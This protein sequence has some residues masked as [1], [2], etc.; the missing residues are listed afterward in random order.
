MAAHLTHQEKMECIRKHF[1]ERKQPR[2]IARELGCSERTVERVV[3]QFIAEG[4]VARKKGSGRPSVV[5]DEVKVAIE[6]GI[7]RK[8][9]ATSAEL[10]KVVASDTG[11][12]VSERTI[13]RTRRQLRYHPVHVSVKPS[14]SAVHIQDR[15]DWCRAHLH[16][17]VRDFVFMDEMGVCIDHHRRVSWIKPGEA[18]PVEEE[19]PFKARL[20]VWGC[21][22]W[23]GKSE[24]HITR[25]SFHSAKY[26]EVLEQ[27]LTPELP[28]GRKRVIQDGVTWHWTEAVVTWFENHRVRLVTDFPA[29]SPDL[30][31]I[32]YVWGWMKYRTAAA[33]P[34][35]AHSLE[36]AIEEAWEDLEQSTI[37]HY[38]EHMTTVMREIIEAE[39]GHSH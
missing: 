34:H 36:A 20:N 5:T 13:R 27:C 31:V 2:T 11:R 29:K 7:Q 4:E 38:I 16:D 12:R 6:R 17:N 23:N 33:E 22:W 39:G 24:L 35:D 32:E 3:E 15:L 26:L 37:R 9:K 30:N 14:L 18:R 28:F 10:A 25:D 19:S 8:R 1:H 21:I